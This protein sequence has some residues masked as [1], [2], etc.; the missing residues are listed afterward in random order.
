VEEDAK[1]VDSDFLGCIQYGWAWNDNKCDASRPV[2]CEYE[3]HVVQ[4]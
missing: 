4:P 2:V 3:P 1:C